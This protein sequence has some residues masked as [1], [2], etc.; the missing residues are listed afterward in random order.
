MEKAWK[1]EL[2]TM[3]RSKPVMLKEEEQ[4]WHFGDEVEEMDNKLNE[5]KW[6]SFTPGS[7]AEEHVIIAAIQSKESLGFDVT[8]A[9]K[10]MEAG[11]RAFEQKDYP[12]MSKL[13]GRVMDCLNRAPVN[14]AHPHWQYACYEQFSQLESKVSF[15]NY[16]FDRSDPA[17]GERTYYGWLAQICAAAA[18]TCIEGYMTDNIK[19]TLGELWSYP[20]TPNTYNDDI[21]YEYAFLAAVAE[22]G[23][24]VTSADIAEQWLAL[25]PF[26]WSAED[27]ALR[28]LKLGIY[29]PDSGRLNNPYCE[30]IG[31]QMRGAV[32]GQLAPG[33]THEAARLA[34]MDGVISHHNNGVLGE[35]FNAVLV[36]LAYVK[37]DVR[38]LVREAISLIPDDS[39]YYSVVRFAL[40]QCEQNE[41]WLPAWRACEKR[42]EQYN[43]IHA[44]PNAAAE[45]I[46]LWYGEGDFDK[47]LHISMMQ[48]YDVD[49]NAAQICTVIGVIHGKDALRAQWTQPI[50][51]TLHSYMRSCK[52][53][54]IRDLAR[55]TCEMSAKLYD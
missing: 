13:A 38:A 32:A 15:P 53:M 26:G 18:G 36:S 33:N 16:A 17:Y 34:F 40:D 27:I 4:N 49:C 37:N 11:L 21:T 51:D 6:C 35:V 20:R 44:Y 19:S 7:G 52:E 3:R 50:G 48:G 23:K 10:L 46:A 55:M 42:Y 28:N 22:K 8:E 14:P 31:A 54:S 24:A 9:E 45:V 47:T 39:E 2:D 5:M 29:P 1:L 12:A 43:W 25:V 41:D 30:W